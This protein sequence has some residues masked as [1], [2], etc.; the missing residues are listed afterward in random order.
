MTGHTPG[1]WRLHLVDDTTI[2]DKS[3]RFVASVCGGDEDLVDQDYN[4]PD[5]WPILEANARLIAS[6]PDL[7]EALKHARNQMQHPDQL[8]DE[9]IAK[10]TGEPT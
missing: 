6:A 5:E 3:G 2:I 9:A 8:I 4:N 7:L 1:P 10:A